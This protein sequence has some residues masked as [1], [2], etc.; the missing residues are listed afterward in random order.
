MSSR[1]SSKQNGTIW[2]VE[3]LAAAITASGWTIAAISKAARLKQGLVSDF[4]SGKS[5]LPVMAAKLLAGVLKADQFSMPKVKDKPQT[6]ATCQGESDADPGPAEE[7]PSL[8][9]ARATFLDAAAPGSLRI[10]WK[11]ERLISLKALAERL[12]KSYRQLYCWAR[13][14]LK[15]I[16]L[17]TVCL[18]SLHTSEEAFER[19]MVALNPEVEQKPPTPSRAALDRRAAKAAKA[20]EARGW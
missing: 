16:R 12:G 11:Q 17:E 9:E 6:A 15:G 1:F 10:D 13:T 7:G 2:T 14:G 8:A 18:G 3:S 19:F 20:L 4:L 5:D